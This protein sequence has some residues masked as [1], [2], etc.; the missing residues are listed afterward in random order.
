MD[1]IAAICSFLHMTKT[2]KSAVR[3]VYHCDAYTK[4]NFIT[5]GSAALPRNG[6]E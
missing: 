4:N 3:I 1:Y 6:L 2:K 5:P